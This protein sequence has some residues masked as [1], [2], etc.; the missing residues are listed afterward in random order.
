MPKDYLEDGFVE[1]DPVHIGAVILRVILPLKCVGRSLFFVLHDGPGVRHSFA[2]LD[3]GEND[4]GLVFNLKL[5]SFL[6]NLL[7]NSSVDELLLDLDDFEEDVDP[8]LLGQ[9]TLK[10]L[11]DGDSVH[12]GAILVRVIPLLRGV[13]RSFFLGFGVSFPKLRD[14]H[15][16]VRR[17]L[18]LLFG[19][20]EP[21]DEG[22]T[23][24]VDLDGHLL[25]HILLCY[26]CRWGLVLYLKMLS[27]L[28]NLLGN[29]SVDE[30]LPDLDDVDEDSPPRSGCP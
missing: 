2:V 19:L 4:W 10:G 17:L 25:G 13:G 24:V 26:R 21:H 18:G 28:K 20:F 6:K 30:A 12:D 5:L 22:S 1:G 29:N 11:V 27:F 7:G 3:D 23:L 16:I 14:L 9:V 8:P 15:T